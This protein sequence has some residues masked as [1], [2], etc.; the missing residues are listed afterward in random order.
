MKIFI[1]KKLEIHA[2]WRRTWMGVPSKPFRNKRQPWNIEVTALTEK[3]IHGKG[4]KHPAGFKWDT[5]AI[6]A[7]L[8]KRNFDWHQLSQN[9]LIEMV[10]Q[11]INTYLI[12]ISTCWSGVDALMSLLMFVL[13]SKCTMMMRLV[14]PNQTVMGPKLPVCVWRY[15]RENLARCWEVCVEY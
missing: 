5:W 2:C 13:S 6:N 4:A 12:L 9:L 3:I 7:K 8:I 10:D 15:V 11:S 1:C 14:L